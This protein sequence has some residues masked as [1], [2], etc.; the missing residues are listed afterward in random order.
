MNLF[1]T[2]LS[3]AWIKEKMHTCFVKQGWNV[4]EKTYRNGP[5]LV[6]ERLGEKTF[7]LTVDE[8]CKFM[9]EIIGLSN[10]S[11]NIT[12]EQVELLH[13]SKKL[14]CFADS[15][16]TFTCFFNDGFN[17]DT[18]EYNYYLQFFGQ[19][20]SKNDCPDKI[21]RLKNIIIKNLCVQFEELLRLAQIAP[22]KLNQ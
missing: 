21:I 15:L 4:Y 7:E 8:N 22:E 19:I 11:C 1:F 13:K 16:R 17:S 10:V 2:P 6:F 12:F 14:Q 18:D 3:P 20:K 9:L 5:A